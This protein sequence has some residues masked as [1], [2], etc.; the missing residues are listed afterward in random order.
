MAD[1]C[2]P[3]R[4]GGRSSDYQIHRLPVEGGAVS[5]AAVVG[6]CLTAFGLGYGVGAWLA[7]V[8]RAFNSLD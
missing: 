6:Y 8:R 5:T 4:V 7:L 2:T 1:V 3:G